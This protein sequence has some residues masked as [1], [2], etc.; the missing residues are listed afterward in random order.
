MKP[1]NVG[2]VRKRV[3]VRGKRKT[4]SRVI[5]VRAQQ[6]GMQA[7]R[8]EM[9]QE[10]LD[11]KTLPLEKRLLSGILSTV[12]G[13]KHVAGRMYS[14]NHD[15]VNS[16]SNYS[17][18]ALALGAEKTKQQQNSGVPTQATIHPNA[19]GRFSQHE[20]TGSAASAYHRRTSAERGWEAV[21][22]AALHPPPGT[23]SAP[24]HVLEYSHGVRTSPMEHDRIR[25]EETI[26]YWR[27]RYSTQGVS[28]VPQNPNK[29][30]R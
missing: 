8:R 9:R 15:G 20:T 5:S 27:Q 3:M 25:R 29:W 10:K 16:G 28:Y 1:T 14:I 7:L 2:K 4:Y 26:N 17:W 22:R 19:F 18:L 30:V 11:K 21:R 12:R 23:V 24:A 13:K 6:I